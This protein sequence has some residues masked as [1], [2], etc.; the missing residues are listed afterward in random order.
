MLPHL[1][2]FV[3]VINSKPWLLIQISLS[4]IIKLLLELDKFYIVLFIYVKQLKKDQDKWVWN[5]L[6]WFVQ[7]FIKGIQ[8]FTLEVNINLL[9]IKPCFAWLPSIFQLLKV[10]QMK[11]ISGSF[12]FIVVNNLKMLRMRMN[13][14]AF[15]HDT[16]KIVK[17][18]NI[19]RRLFIH[20]G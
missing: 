9:Y 3:E 10:H 2:K 12:C 17:K 1:Q 13:W 14:W 18:I 16:S 4:L 5:V 15:W 8:S 7:G 20:Q 11:T 19:W 6:N